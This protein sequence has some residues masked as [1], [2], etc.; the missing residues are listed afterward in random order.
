MDDASLQLKHFV[1]VF[2]LCKN[3]CSSRV[4]L[5][6]ASVAV[7]QNTACLEARQSGLAVA[8]AAPRRRP[9]VGTLVRGVTNDA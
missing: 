8:P 3:S 9:I 2:T 7:P 5:C 4:V 1:T 6:R